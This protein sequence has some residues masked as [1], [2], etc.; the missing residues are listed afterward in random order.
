M[1]ADPKAVDVIG[2]DSAVKRVAEVLAEPVPVSGAT[3]TVRQ[4]VTLGLLDPSLRLRA[5][6]SAVVTVQIVPAPLVRTLRNRPIH[7]ENL[8]E[9]LQADALPPAVELTLRGNR[10]ELSHVSGDDIKAFI[11]LAGLGPGQYMLDVHVDSPEAS[12]TRIDPATVQVRIA[13]GK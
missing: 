1:S 8:G 2:P 13:R 11:D 4:T 6:R 12:V 3:N 10:D 5:T 9:T 7:L